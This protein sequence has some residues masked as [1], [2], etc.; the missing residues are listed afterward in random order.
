MRTRM[1]ESNFRYADERI[2][3]HE[4]TKLR[5]KV[6]RSR[7]RKKEKNFFL[8]KNAV[9]LESKTTPLSLVRTSFIYKDINLQNHQAEERKDLRP[10]LTMMGSTYLAGG[11]K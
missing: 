8:V 1:P 10:F 6:A 11:I 9:F 5:Q 7:R 2:V 4:N 3:N